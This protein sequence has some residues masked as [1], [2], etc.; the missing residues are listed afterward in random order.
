MENYIFSPIIPIMKY[1][2]E[3]SDL[4]KQY[5]G[6]I[7]ALKSVNLKVPQNSFLALLGKNGAGKS[8]FIDIISSLI[9]KTSGDI[10]VLGHDL[11]KNRSLVKSLISVVPQE[12]NLPIYDKAIDVLINQ[13][14]YYGINRKT[15]EPIA[16][17]YLSIMQLLHKKDQPS[18]RLSGG[19]KRRLMIARAMMHNPEVIFL[20]EPTAGVDVEIRSIIWQ[21]LKDL[22][23]DGKTIILT[24]HYLEE[25]EALCDTLAVLENGEI[26]LAGNMRDILA[27][28]EHKNLSITVEAPKSIKKTLSKNIK[29]I[30]DNTL[31]VTTDNHNNSINK[32]V[33]EIISAG[34]KITNIKNSKSDLEKFL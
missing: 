24:T 29:K 3:I 11:I 19:M 5:P 16:E 4:K 21:F 33:A 34:F 23:K 14:G 9:S 2:L 31:E 28:V 27:K 32:A 13:A 25:A 30:D 26:K 17:K 6:G 1:A 12:I 8:T 15:A 20:D 22:Q 18:V 10:S 7:K